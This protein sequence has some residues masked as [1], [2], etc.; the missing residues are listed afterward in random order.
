MDEYS[1]AFGKWVLRRRWLVIM[2]VIAASVLL[3]SGARLLTFNGNYRI[4]F[5]PDNPYL[6][7]FDLIER[8]YTKTDNILFVIKN[9]EGDLFNPR[10]LDIVK[11]MTDDAWRMPYSSR[12][13]SVTNY[14][15]TYAEDDDLTVRDLVP[16]PKSLT[17][18]EAAYVR[19][20]AMTDPLV[21]KRLVSP[22]GTTT[23]I[24]V[25][26]QIPE[27]TKTPETPIMAY[28][29]DMVAKYTADDPNLTIVL[30]GNT[31]HNNAFV[32]VSAHDLQVLTP[33]MYLFLALTMIVFLRSVLGVIVTLVVIAISAT[34]AMGIAGWIGIELSPQSAMA[35]TIILT[36]AVANPV[37]FLVTM[38]TAMRDGM[39]R[40]DA[41][42]ES[43][44][45]NA[46][47]I[48]LTSI[49]TAIGFTCL[50][51]GD[52]PPF[53]DLGNIAAIGTMLAWAY[54]MTL[55]PAIISLLPMR[56]PAQ[57]GGDTT[58]LGKLAE[59]VIARR[60]PVLCLTSA[61]AI[62][63]IALIPRLEMNDNFVHYFAK[64]LEFRDAADFAN[65]NLTGVYTLEYSLKS[66]EPGGISD[67]DYMK[68]LAAFADWYEKQPYITHV[69]PVTDIMT[70][71][72]RNMHGD[73]DA[74]Y[75][76][77]EDR[78]LAAQYLLLYEMSL[79]YGLDLNNQINVDKSATRMTV[80]LK[81]VS[82]KETKKIL[83]AAEAW[84][85]EN[86]PDYMFSAASSSTVMFTF[87]ADKNVTSMLYG[88]L[89]AFILISGILLFALKSLRIGLISLIPNM[90]PAFMAFGIWAI[91]STNVGWSVAFVTVTALGIIVDATVHFLSKYLRARREQGYSTEDAVRYAF[92]TVGAAIWVSAVVLIVGFSVLGFS[93][94]EMN[95]HLGLLTALTIAVALLVDFTLLPALLMTL[96]RKDRS[97][98]APRKVAAA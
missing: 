66:T 48:F 36:I 50:N 77:P 3:I 62:A 52:A 26:M 81:D 25:T 34:T 75:Q 28:A 76:L 51:F 16:D 87:L 70:R 8:T 11:Q 41:I 80:L 69:S 19:N 37:H 45:L 44:R 74:W 31:P 43:I 83:A 5:S 23:G 39:S 6:K 79:P 1:V 71:L 20:V 55:L 63:L 15:H 61:L 93:D 59:T 88:T 72:N 24:F 42:V 89:A 38:F 7:A 4:Y 2:A 98:E 90:V 56:A 27:G 12:V 94:F 46:Q 35:P 67:P 73:D 96:D 54:A 30:T 13:D 78:E 91:F 86:L 92:S 17:D 33:L 10:V 40:H 57:R 21:A 68:H 85:H 29:R 14:Q 18:A 64:G 82:T 53:G 65:D 60:M 58:L 47:P 97:V 49:T 22:D 84:Q 32:E 9:N 95:K